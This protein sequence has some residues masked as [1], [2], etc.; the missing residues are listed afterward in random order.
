MSRLRMIRGDT[1][2][3][4]ATV[5]DSNGVVNLTGKSLIFT[6]KTA[7]SDADVNAIAQ[8]KSSTGG[9]VITDAPNGLATITLLPADTRT[10]G[11][12]F[13]VLV[14]DL[15]LID[16]SNVYTVASGRMEVTPDVTI[17][18]S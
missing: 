16:G 3:F 13:Q 14:W 11:D 12:E 2:S 6:L 7:Y 15:Q 4:S 18:V 1:F 8:K 17:S 9:I 10:L 5:T